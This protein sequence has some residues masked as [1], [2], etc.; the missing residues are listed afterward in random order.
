MS[1]RKPLPEI[2]PC[3][4][5]GGKG[6]SGGYGPPGKDYSVQCQR[7]RASGPYRKTRRGAINA[8]NRRHAA[9]GVIWRNNGPSERST[10]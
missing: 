2:E 4:F 7:C 8:Y 6:A 5:C 1:K 3:P 9:P 10:V